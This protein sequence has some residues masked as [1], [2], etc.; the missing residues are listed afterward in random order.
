VWTGGHPWPL[1]SR[2]TRRIILVLRSLRRL[3][4]P[5]A[6]LGADLGALTGGIL[7]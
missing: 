1:N 4:A 2:L 3:L 7:A 5:E 6:G